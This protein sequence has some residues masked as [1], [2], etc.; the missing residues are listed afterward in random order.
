MLNSQFA[1]PHWSVSFANRACLEATEQ[2]CYLYTSKQLF[3]FLVIRGNSWNKSLSRIISVPLQMCWA[4]VVQRGPDL[5][6]CEFHNDG[7]WPD[8]FERK[9]SFIGSYV[10]KLKCHSSK[11]KHS[12][13]L[14]VNQSD[15]ILVSQQIW[16]SVCVLLTNISVPVRGMT[17]IFPWKVPSDTFWSG[18][19]NPALTTL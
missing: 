15:V 13:L 1:Y 4:K 2:V 18:F 3:E 19:I 14:W 5:I 11:R 8:L 12:N 6:F 16:I 17:S 7:A 10:V 9:W